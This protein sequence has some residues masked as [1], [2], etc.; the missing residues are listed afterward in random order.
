[1]KNALSEGISRRVVERSMISYYKI[2]EVMYIGW[3]L[4]YIDTY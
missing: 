1:M 3:S 4:E 2:S